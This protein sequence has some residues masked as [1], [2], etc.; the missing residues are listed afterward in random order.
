[1]PIPENEAEVRGKGQQTPSGRSL[2]SSGLSLSLCKPHRNRVHIPGRRAAADCWP[3]SCLHHS[4][5][6]RDLL[7]PECGPRAGWEVTPSSRAYE[8][9]LACRQNRAKPG[10]GSFGSSGECMSRLK[11]P[12]GT[13]GKLRLG[14]AHLLGRG[15]EP[16][17]P[18]SFQSIGRE[19]CI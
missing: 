7:G 5:P 18:A 14:P 11:A 16:P 1:M 3:H 10:C 12:R 8:S 2:L 13:F 15:V 6:G 17:I 19:Y 4:I 9:C